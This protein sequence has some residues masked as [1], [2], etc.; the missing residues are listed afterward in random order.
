VRLNDVYG[1]EDFMNIILCVMVCAFAVVM[2]LRYRPEGKV[3]SRLFL[4]TLAA[5]FISLFAVNDFTGVWAFIWTA[6]DVA[7]CA[8][9]LMLYR[10]ELVLQQ[11]ERELRRKKAVRAARAE[12]R[13]AMCRE[14]RMAR[15]SIYYENHSNMAA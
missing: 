11:T 14:E 1:M 8:T 5:G 15:V 13:P 7:C 6:A 3:A 12:R 9:M 2:K 4:L 10:T